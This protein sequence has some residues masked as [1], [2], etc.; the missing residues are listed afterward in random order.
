MSTA[1]EDDDEFVQT[2]SFPLHRNPTPSPNLVSTPAMH[3]NGQRGHGLKIKHGLTGQ[4]VR[5]QNHTSDVVL[6]DA[7]HGA[8]NANH[9]HHRAANGIPDSS[10]KSGESSG[11]PSLPRTSEIDF[12]HEGGEEESVGDVGGAEQ[13]EART[14]VG[15]AGT[16]SMQMADVVDRINRLQDSVDSLLW[17]FTQSHLDSHP[18]LLPT[19]KDSQSRRAQLYPHS[20]SFHSF[21]V[22]SRSYTR[23]S[24]IWYHP[25]PLYSRE[26]ERVK[27]YDVTKQDRE[28]QLQRAKARLRLERNQLLARRELVG[29]VGASAGSEDVGYLQ[30]TSTGNAFERSS[31]KQPPPKSVRSRR[32]S[33]VKYR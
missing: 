15:N 2:S 30:T 24:N 32:A 17:T 22:P 7:R 29:V 3:L 8:N 16:T 33:M 14:P 10:S 21:P 26:N 28:A 11:V 23:G 12:R 1:D 5:R 19:E 31:Q 20:S 25:R 9:H 4:P 18:H 27:S 6:I 13:A